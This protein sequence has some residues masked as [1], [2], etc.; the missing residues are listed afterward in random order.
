MNRRSLEGTPKALMK[1]RGGTE[2]R[3]F[4]ATG[5]IR[6]TSGRGLQ[7]RARQLTPPA[8]WSPSC[9]AVPAG[10]R[11]CTAE[12]PRHLHHA[13]EL[14]HSRSRGNRRIPSPR[15]HGRGRSPFTGARR[16]TRRVGMRGAL[17][18]IVEPDRRRIAFGGILTSVVSRKRSFP[19]AMRCS[20]A[21]GAM[22]PPQGPPAPK[23][24]QF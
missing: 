8:D 19:S 10:P 14:S 13:T 22:P 21:S 24:G 1:R 17:N 9:V 15:R 16:Q 4:R 2:R 6:T 12:F 23:G 3:D 20:S 7:P 18:L 11:P 5:R